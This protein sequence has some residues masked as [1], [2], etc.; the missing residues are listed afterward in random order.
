MLWHILHI[1][2]KE[3]KIPWIKLD[4]KNSRLDPFHFG[5]TK[6]KVEINLDV[7]PPTA[8]IVRDSSQ[9]ISQWLIGCFLLNVASVINLVIWSNNP[10]CNSKRNLNKKAWSFISLQSSSSGY[11]RHFNSHGYQ[12]GSSGKECFSEFGW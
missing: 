10:P 5:D 3:T 2:W 9:F 4:T 8:V 6:V 7:P 12:S 1:C 11:K